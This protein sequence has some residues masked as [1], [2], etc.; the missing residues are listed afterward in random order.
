MKRRMRTKK[1][2]FICIS[3]LIFILFGLKCY[4]TTAG[5]YTDEVYYIATSF[6]FWQGD[7]VLV[8]DW[9]TAQM[10]GFLLLPFV[11]LY[12]IIM[13]TT[14]GIVLYFRFIYLIFKTLVA[15]FCLRKLR[16]YGVLGIIGISIWYFSS[17]QSID[18]LSYNTIPIAM[19][20]M[21]EAVYLSE[22]KKNGITYYLC[23][24]FLAAAVLA[25]P[26]C[27]LIYFS[28]VAVGIY[29]ALLWRQK[30]AKKYVVVSMGAFS[31]LVIFTV[32]V[33]SRASLKEVVEN[34]HFIL[35]DNSHNAVG[36]AGMLNLVLKPVR[37][38]W[39]ILK[40][41]TMMTIINTVFSLVLIVSKNLR[42]KYR[43]YFIYAALLCLVFSCLNVITVGRVFVE[44]EFFIPFFWFS[45][46]EIFLMV[47]EKE[48]YV[49]IWLISVLTTLCF[50]L[51]T[52]TGI[53]STSVAMCPLAVFSIVMLP[54]IWTDEEAKLQRKKKCLIACCAGLSSCM[55]VMRLVCTCTDTLFTEDYSCYIE[56]GPLK[57]TYT[58]KTSFEVVTNIMSDLDM[59]SYT[60]ADILFCGRNTSL[61]YLYSGMGCGTMSTYLL[62]VDY[63]RLEQYHELHPDKFPT[64]V[65][66]YPLGSYPIV[67]KDINSDFF[68]FVQSNYEV[69]EI[70]GRFLA[71][72]FNRE[73]MP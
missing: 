9:N 42:K 69:Q 30:P 22:E 63:E 17:P 52:D 13:K 7:A 35:R 62:E 45:L 60:D 50:C 71:V 27:I 40:N 16:K 51:S 57:G 41:Y 56:K 24:I 33:F 23:G 58:D 65:Y 25:Q 55:F 26:L 53:I 12:M 11:Y 46:N 38:G 6:R 37:V 8:D 68:K 44:N 66:Y 18:A 3:V 5:S 54:N 59:I 28:G 29:K 31:M 21:I 73:I 14:E 4:I 34:L 64:V 70:E 48:K 2:I 67:E 36:M 72:S 32:F 19:I 15:V 39:Q 61:A 20:L 1:I 47:N 10:N 43:N 49:S